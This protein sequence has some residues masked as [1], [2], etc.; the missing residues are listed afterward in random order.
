LILCLCN[1]PDADQLA[2]A[3]SYAGCPI[4]SW[5][6][7]FGDPAFGAANSSSEISPTHVYPGPE[8]Y[9]VTLTVTGYSGL[10]DTTTQRV[11]LVY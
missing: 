6:W 2:D 1:P 9:P 11:T 8:T 5:S 10:S 7:D 3:S 4:A